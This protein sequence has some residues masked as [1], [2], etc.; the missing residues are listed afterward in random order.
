[1][2]KARLF[3]LNHAS[4]LSCTRT[5]TCASPYTYVKTWEGPVFTRA[6]AIPVGNDL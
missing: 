6:A 1:M 5:Y 3:H 4:P 2:I